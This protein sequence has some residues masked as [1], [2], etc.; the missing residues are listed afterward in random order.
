M[1]QADGFRKGYPPAPPRAVRRPPAS[2]RWKP[3]AGPET[4]A[5]HSLRRRSRAVVREGFRQQECHR[6]CGWLALTPDR[7]QSTWRTRA[8]EDGFIFRR[9][10]TADRLL[11]HGGG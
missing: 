11:R 5:R 9:G 10:V 7:V 8:G 6:H 2:T 1:N 4:L 3:G